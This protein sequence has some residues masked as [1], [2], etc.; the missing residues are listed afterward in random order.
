MLALRVESGDYCGQVVA[1]VSVSGVLFVYK[2]V[3]RIIPQNEWSSPSDTIAYFKASFLSSEANLFYLKVNTVT[4]TIYDAQ[5]W[6]NSV[7]LF[8]AGSPTSTGVELNFAISP[9][10]VGEAYFNFDVWYLFQAQG[11]TINSTMVVTS[12]I[13]I[14]FSHG[15][16]LR[17]RSLDVDFRS[18]A[19]RRRSMR[20]IDVSAKMH[21]SNIEHSHDEVTAPL[22]QRTETDQHGRHQQHERHQQ[23]QRHDDTAHE[24]Y[25]FNLTMCI[26]CGT[27]LVLIVVN[28][29][30]H[31]RRRRRRRSLEEV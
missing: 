26:L 14:G 28:K 6:V 24:D 30:I 2:D 27:A 3:Y 21:I 29:V 8:E 13:T 25:L 9:G 4:A 7:T 12:S 15:S 11:A 23:R 10:P 31:T 1:D 18:T 16:S 20:S 17:K 5:G 22:N 19:R